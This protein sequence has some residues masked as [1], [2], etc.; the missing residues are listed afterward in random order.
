MRLVKRHQY[1]LDKLKNENYVLV[2]GIAKELNV[3]EVTIRKDFNL[4]EKKGLLFR[5]HGGATLVNPYVVDKPLS[6]KQHLNKSEKH[7]ISMKATNFIED[8][9]VIILGSGTTVLNMVEHFPKD[10]NITVITSSLLIASTLCQ[11]EKVNVIQIGGDVRKSSQS[12]V[13]P[14]AQELMQEISANKLFLGID[15]LD[16]DFGIST[17]NNAEAYLNKLMIKN[18]SKTYILA[19]HSKFG[20]KGLSHIC[21]LKDID[22]IITNKNL[23]EE[24]K[25]TMEKYGIQVILA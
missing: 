20:K 19:D 14:V 25:T 22:F 16:L 1:I 18:V 17:S 13:G 12:T 10:K 11:Y 4:L 7:L 6:H 3:S 9:D 23:N 2:A 15:G 5:N 8:N 21:P 24:T